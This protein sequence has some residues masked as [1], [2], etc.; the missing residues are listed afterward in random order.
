[1]RSGTG[2]VRSRVIP[3]VTGASP[4]KAVAEQVDMPNLHLHTDGH[5]SYQSFSTN[6]LSH[7]Y[8]RHGAST[9]KVE[10]FFLS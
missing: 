4:R 5:L 3:D 2:E 9:N 1:M 7:R 6:F 8:V 10:N